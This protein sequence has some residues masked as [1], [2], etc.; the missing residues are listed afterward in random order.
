M[1]FTLT[2]IIAQTNMI[3]SYMTGENPVSWLTQFVFINLYVYLNNRSK[4][5]YKL[6]LHE[7]QLKLVSSSS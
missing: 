1:L 6:I 3:Y 5:A 2:K 7:N 4:L